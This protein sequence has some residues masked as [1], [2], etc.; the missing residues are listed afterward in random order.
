LSVSSHHCPPPSFPQTRGLEEQPVVAS[1]L[2][3]SCL[4]LPS[5]GITVLHYHTSLKTFIYLLTVWGFEL[6]VLHLLG[7]C[8]ALEPLEPHP[9][10]FFSLIYLLGR[11]SHFAQGQPQIDILLPPPPM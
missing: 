10:P 1:N 6:R 8:L 9:Q 4:S 7:R 5:A 11:V 2:W 3:T